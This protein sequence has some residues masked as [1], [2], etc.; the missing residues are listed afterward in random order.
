MIRSESD[1]EA[2]EIG[3]ICPTRDSGTVYSAFMY[4]TSHPARFTDRFPT[5]D[6]WRKAADW[7]FFALVTGSIGWKFLAVQ[8][9][10]RAR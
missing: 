2:R 4:L 6:G 1:P 5:S 3:Q 7:V 9:G 10:H 8:K